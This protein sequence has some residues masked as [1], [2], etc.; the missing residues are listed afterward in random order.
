MIENQPV[1]CA[2]LD[3]MCFVHPGHVVDDV[4]NRD[5]DKR[6]PRLGIERADVIEVRVLAL[7]NTEAGVP[8]TNES[9]MHIIDKVG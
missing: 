2:E 7:A 8:L 1:I 6:A 9:I 3:R 5:I 4:M